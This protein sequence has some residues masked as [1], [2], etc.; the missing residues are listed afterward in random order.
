[1]QKGLRG[2]QS[3]LAREELVAAGVPIQMVPEETLSRITQ[4]RHQG[5]IGYLSSVPFYDLD[6]I[7]SQAYESGSLPLVLMLDGVTD[8][9]NFGAICRSAEALGA[10]AVVIPER[11]AARINEE[12]VRTSAGALTHFPVCRVKSLAVAARKLQDAGLRLAAATEKGSYP[13]SAAALAGPLC[14]VMGAEDTGISP[15]LLRISD[16]LLGIPMKGRTSSLNV[17]VAAGI[18][19]Y[20]V[21]R[22]RTQTLKN[23]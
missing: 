4:A 21:T 13:P 8:V 10:H 6:E 19:L 9:R 17:S 16:F 12:A 3:R 20:E 22:Q 5:I 23:D 7:V 14:L 18:M 1:M 2:D 11:G 15:E